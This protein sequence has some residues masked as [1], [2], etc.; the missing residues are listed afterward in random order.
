VVG[1]V[2][3]QLEMAINQKFES[4]LLAAEADAFWCF[5]KML[6]GVLDYFTDH[7]PGVHAC[8]AKM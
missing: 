3:P 4:G 7:Q 2:D 6:N 1:D 8:I 5:S